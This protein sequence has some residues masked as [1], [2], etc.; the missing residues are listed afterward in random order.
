MPF[1][2][3]RKKEKGVEMQNITVLE[4]NGGVGK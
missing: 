2:Y 1:L 4:E 3:A